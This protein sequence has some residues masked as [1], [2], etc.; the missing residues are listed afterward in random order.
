MTDLIIL[1]DMKKNRIRI[2]KATLHALGTPRYLSLVINPEEF[3]LGI[4]AG[5]PEDKTAHRIRANVLTTKECC[6]LYSSSL[7]EALLSLCPEWHNYGKYRMTGTLIPEA[8]MVCFDMR[9]AVFE[10]TRQVPTC[11][12][13]TIH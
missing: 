7:I 12:E 10:E 13:Q 11:S 4:T 1:V 8:N 3:T 2:H 5:S 6:E 9:S